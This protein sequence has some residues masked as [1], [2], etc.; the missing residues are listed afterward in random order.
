MPSRN[1]QQGG[2][3]SKTRSGTYYKKKDTRSYFESIEELR[4]VHKHLFEDDPIVKERTR[5]S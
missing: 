5:V 2:K 3:V 1:Q 4:R